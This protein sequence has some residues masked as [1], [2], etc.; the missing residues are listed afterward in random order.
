MTFSNIKN[1]INQH[2]NRTWSYCSSRCASIKETSELEWSACLY[3]CT[4]SKRQSMSKSKECLEWCDGVKESP[5]A[6][7]YM[8]EEPSDGEHLLWRATCIESC[9]SVYEEDEVEL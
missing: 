6:E 9:I 7:A 2:Q 1:N 5:Q 8:S 3:G 4:A